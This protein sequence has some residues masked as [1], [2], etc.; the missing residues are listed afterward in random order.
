MK[1]FGFS[2]SPRHFSAV[3]ATFLA[4][5]ALSLNAAP[6]QAASEK[7]YRYLTYGLGAATAYMAVKKKTVP[8]VIGAAGTYLVYKKWNDAKNDRRDRE[9]WGYGR[10]RDH[11]GRW[12]RDRRDN[13]RDNRRNRDYGYRR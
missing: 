2:P 10:G 1:L 13:N 6:A 12:Q 5:G 3:L 9:R 8:A 4:V 11:D 7:T